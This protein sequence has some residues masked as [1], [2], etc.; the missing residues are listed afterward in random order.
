MVPGLVETDEPVDT[1]DDDNPVVVTVPVNVVSTGTPEEV[2]DEP[3]CCCEVEDAAGSETEG[4]TDV[5]DK[6]TSVTVA[7]DSDVNSVENV[8][9]VVGTCGH[10]W[11]RSSS[12]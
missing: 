7:V 9:A 12:C 11:L 8:L 4:K 2:V 3:G 1:V 5:I 10:S 6:V